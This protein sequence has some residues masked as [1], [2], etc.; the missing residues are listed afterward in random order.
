MAIQIS[1]IEERL[2]RLERQGEAND[3]LLRF[4]L[5]QDRK[6]ARLLTSA[7]TA[8]AE[9][10]FTQPARRFGVSI[11]VFRG[12]DTIVSSIVASTSRLGTHHMVTNQRVEL[13]GNVAHGTALVEAQHAADDAYLLLKNLYSYQL[14]SIGGVWQLHRV[15]IETMWHDGDARVLFPS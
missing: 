7:F 9:L 11:D 4:A 14:R 10:D 12:R 5:G 15:L 6:D 13:N 2:H 3:A 8:D 1:S